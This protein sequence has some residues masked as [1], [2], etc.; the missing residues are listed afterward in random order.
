MV[1]LKGIMRKQ[2]IEV[3]VNSGDYVIEEVSIS[4]FELQKADEL[5]IK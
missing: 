2:L 5:F 3:I 4:P 1:A